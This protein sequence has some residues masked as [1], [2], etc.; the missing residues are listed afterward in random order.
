MSGATVSLIVAVVGVCGTL[1]SAVITQVLSQRAKMRESEQAERARAAE[2][3]ASE[4]QRR[5]DQLRSCYV[6]LNALDRHYRDAMLAYAYALKSGTAGTEAEEVGSARRAQR[7]ARA[8]AQMIASDPVLRIESGV[9]A[10][11]T[12]AYRRLMQAVGEPDPS[13][14]QAQFDQVIDLLD[15]IIEKLGHVR[16]L[17]RVELGVAQDPPAR[18]NPESGQAAHQQVGH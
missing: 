3:R 4:E 18:Y 12:A 1:A 5:T 16:A 13:A 17:M 2:Q 8:E 9:N 7:D 6:Q 11:L 10:Q 15:P 14:R